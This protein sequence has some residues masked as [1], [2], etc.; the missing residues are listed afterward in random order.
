MQ[1]LVKYLE[2]LNDPKCDLGNVAVAIRAC[3]AV[4]DR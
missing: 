4:P 2:T 1:D 3:E